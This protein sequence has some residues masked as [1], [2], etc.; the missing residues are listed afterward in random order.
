MTAIVNPHAPQA[1]RDDQASFSTLPEFLDLTD[2]GD[3]PQS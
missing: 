1:L 3:A 2:S